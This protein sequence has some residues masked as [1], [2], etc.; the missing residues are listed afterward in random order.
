M[1]PPLRRRCQALLLLDLDRLGFRDPGRDTGLAGD[2][3]SVGVRH[4]LGLHEGLRG[5]PGRA[6]LAHTD[7][8]K[9][10]RCLTK[11]VTFAPDSDGCEVTWTVTVPWAEVRASVGFSTVW[12]IEKLTSVPSGSFV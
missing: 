1:E 11:Y 6:G 9:L 2:L 8:V 7:L 10:P 3:R 4:A 5:V 12:A